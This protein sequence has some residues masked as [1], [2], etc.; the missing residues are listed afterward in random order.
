MPAYIIFTVVDTVCRIIHGKGP[1]CNNNRIG[2]DIH[3]DGAP[4]VGSRS[5]IWYNYT[6]LQLPVLNPKECECASWCG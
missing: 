2:G 4:L 3:F 1:K 5:I 6:V